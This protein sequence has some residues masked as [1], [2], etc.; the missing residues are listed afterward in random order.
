MARG[1][2]HAQKPEGQRRRRNKPTHDTTVYTDSGEIYGP[3]LED[4]TG[5]TWSASVEA[6]FEDW[7]RMPQAR[8]F[9]RTDWRR[10]AM[11]APLVE[12]METSPGAA[13]MSEI[14]MNEERLGAT[15]TD[16]MRARMAISRDD[17]E[18]GAD[19]LSLVPDDDEDDDDVLDRA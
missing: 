14:R 16:R 9:M 7:R 11:I 18:E 15:V 1:T 8:D 13:A 17:D 3:T 5:K 4:L 10:L 6:W 2:M 12:K 19:V